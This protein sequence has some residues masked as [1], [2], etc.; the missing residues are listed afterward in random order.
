LRRGWNERVLCSY[1]PSPHERYGLSANHHLHVLPDQSG[2]LFTAGLGTPR[3]GV[4]L[5]E[6]PADL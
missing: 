1:P 5:V 6:W 2:V 3:A 4:Y